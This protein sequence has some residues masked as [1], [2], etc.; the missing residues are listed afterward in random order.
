MRSGFR[1]GAY[2]CVCRP[3][4]YFPNVTDSEGGIANHWDSY[5]NGTLLET[6]Y[7]DVSDEDLQEFYDK[8][9]RCLPCQPGCQTCQ[10]GSPCYVKYD[11]LWR[12]V[13]L[14][15]Q[16]FC[17]TITVVLGICVFQLRKC[18][19]RDQKNFRA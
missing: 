15:L 19:V 10:D 7:G 5:F 13:P 2:Q 3:G 11:I 4:H 1:R 17:M 6:K 12:G 8:E 18:K 16:S 9:F 14:G